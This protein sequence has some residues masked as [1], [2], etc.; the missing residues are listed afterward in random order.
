MAGYLPAGFP[1]SLQQIN[2]VFEGRGLNLFAY[3]G[4]TWYTAA[5][6]SGTFPSGAI[7]FSDFYNKGPNPPGFATVSL[8]TLP[9]NSFAYYTGDF[10]IDVTL[11]LYANGIWVVNDDTGEMFS[12]NWG[13]PTTGGAGSSY[14]VRFTRTSYTPIGGPEYSTATTGWENLGVARSINVYTFFDNIDASSGTYTIEI[15]TDSGGANI[16]AT[17]T[18]VRL[19]AVPGSPP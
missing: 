10:I 8:A 7:S 1:I 3:R 2:T 5:G 4:T 18:G 9:S 14:W 17:R 12:G 13:S 6:G 16:I 15:A 19:F 11:I